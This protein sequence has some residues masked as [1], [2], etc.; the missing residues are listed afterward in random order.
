[1]GIITIGN[2]LTLA[3][4]AAIVALT[5]YM[6]RGNRSV[7]L[8]REYGKRLKD[9][10][11]AFTEEKAAAVRDYGVELE[12]Q[13]TSAKEVLNR[14]A[15]TDE[16]LAE[17]ADAV[18]KIGERITAYDKSM[19]ELVRTTARVQENLNRLRD[20]ASF[21]EQVGKKISAAG[22]R[23]GEIEKN[24]G[25]LELRFERENAGALQK[26]AESLLSSVQSTVNELQATAE[27]VER[28]VE[29]HRAAVDRIEHERRE[30]LARDI[31]IINKTL[32]EA[33]QKAAERAED[34][35]A[36]VDRAEHE[37]REQLARD[38]EA[39]NET[40]TEA[41]QKAAE[42]AEEH[43]AAVDRAEHERREHLARDEEAI[44]ETV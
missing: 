42:R 11:A 6:D 35:R 32:G 25:A 3:V 2:I 16:S 43:R 37:R 7:D 19:E 17:K 20:E 33:V 34:H 36:A 38:V 40:V 30:Q 31:E 22:A 41:V 39:I 10:I 21:V 28:Q 12:V 8:A 14:L 9:D 26:T 5:R 13:K 44:N 29:D 4:A 24:V 15:L 23:A 18:A 27:T 1:M